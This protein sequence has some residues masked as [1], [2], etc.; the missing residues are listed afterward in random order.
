M[1]KLDHHYSTSL[2]SADLSAA[3][4]VRACLC[5]RLDPA[6]WPR[7]RALAGRADLDWA[8]VLRSAR[9]DGLSSLLY[10]TVRGRDLLPPDV[11]QSLQSVYY[12]LA[13]RNVILSHEL[14]AALRGLEAKGVE[15]IVLKGAALAELIYRNMAVRPMCDLD[16][17]VHASDVPAAREALAELGYVPRGVE[18]RAGDALAYENELA[19]CK[20]GST[21]T[22]LELHWGLLD[23]P[24]Y[25]HKLPMAWFWESA[26]AVRLGDTPARVLGP[27]AQVLYL[28]AHLVLHH[29]GGSRLW[30]HDVAEVVTFYRES[31]DWAEVLARA[32]AY[33]LVLPLQHVLSD[34]ASQGCV[35]LPSHLLAQLRALRPSLEEARV[36]AWLTAE[37]RPVAYRL[38]ADLSSMAGWKRR[39][40][41]AWNNVFPSLGYMRHRYRFSHPAGL[42]VYYP[43]RWLLGAKSALGLLCARFI[44]NSQR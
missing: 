42:L 23:S 34:L 32:Q 1:W 36:F 19:L 12:V 15:A 9:A 16:L 27:E 5:A 44:T 7:A 14:K 35:P 22:V 26:L 33:D 39:L 6:F 38:W 13:R 17:L 29:Q 3:G 37:E 41:Y 11:E 25:Q 31:L 21:D 10:E 43:Y 24:Y 4:F 20:P 18:T 2:N 28:C 8:A 40:R 30:L